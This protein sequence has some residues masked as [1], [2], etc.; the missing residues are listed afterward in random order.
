MYK[1]KIMFLKINLKLKIYTEY[2]KY[3]TFKNKTYFG[4]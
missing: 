4:I 3:R 1:K 2:H